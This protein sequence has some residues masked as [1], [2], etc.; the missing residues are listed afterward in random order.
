MKLLFVEDDIEIRENLRFYLKSIF[1]EVIEVSNGKEAL[2]EYY[3]CTPDIILLDINIPKLNGIEVAK[4]IRERDNKT[5]IIILTAHDDRDI[6]IQAIELKLT[7]YLLKPVSRNV[8]KQTLIKA[9]SDVKEIQ[10]IDL[11]YDY[12][13]NLKNKILKHKNEIIKLTNNEIKLFNRYCNNT[14]EMF[15]N[16]DLSSLLYED[17][18]YNEN[19]VRMFLKRFRKNINPELIINIYGL[20]YRFNYFESKLNN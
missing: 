17:E 12:K 15:S 3:N 13:W 19:K 9:I 18:E 7:K 5:V 6:L 20:G 11:M 16:E 14:Q 8:L 10:N 1:R 4:E 2:K